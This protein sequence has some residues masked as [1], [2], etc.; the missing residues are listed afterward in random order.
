LRC[1]YWYS[2]CICSGDVAT[3]NGVVDDSRTVASV[4]IAA[5]IVTFITLIVVTAGGCR[6]VIS[7]LASGSI[8]TVLSTVVVLMLLLSR[9][10]YNKLSALN[11][12]D[13][14]KVFIMPKF[15]F[16]EEMM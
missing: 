3:D 4:D 9:E 7:A 2:R 11:Q 10:L 15:I 16:L 5:G 13:C 6:D 14:L 8:T 12:M 1:G